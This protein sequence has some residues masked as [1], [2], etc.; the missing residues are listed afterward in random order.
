[1]DVVFLATNLVLKG[2]IEISLLLAFVMFVVSRNEMHLGF[3]CIWEGRHLG[4]MV[5][6]QD[7]NHFC[8]C[9]DFTEIIRG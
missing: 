7:T 2:G 5:D 4:Y 6:I 3:F 1:M 8:Y 9:A